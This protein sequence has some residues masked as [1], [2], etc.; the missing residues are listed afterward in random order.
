MISTT[1]GQT[2][3]TKNAKAAFSSNGH[4]ASRRVAKTHD[5][6]DLQ[7]GVDYYFELVDHSNR[8]YLTAQGKGVKQHDYI[9]LN[10]DS[11]PRRY[12]VEMIDYYSDPSDLWIALLNPIA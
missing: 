2:E 8:A 3:P 7:Q 12:Q 1:N 5:Y 10:V 6:T 4:S 9:L 11:T